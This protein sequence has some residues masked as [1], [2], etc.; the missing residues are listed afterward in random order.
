MERGMELLYWEL[1]FAAMVLLVFMVPMNATV[2][3]IIVSASFTKFV[4][5]LILFMIE[6]SKGEEES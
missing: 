4:I 3:F 2:S 1:M 6:D 5:E